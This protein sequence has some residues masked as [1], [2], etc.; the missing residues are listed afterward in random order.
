MSHALLIHAA[1]TDRVAIADPVSQRPDPD[2]TQQG[3]D[4]GE[5]PEEPVIEPEPPEDAE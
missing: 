3:I 1:D 4:Q 5:R 2:D